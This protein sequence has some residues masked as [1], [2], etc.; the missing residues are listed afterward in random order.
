M[1]AISR[2]FPNLSI[3]VQIDLGQSL[4]KNIVITFYKAVLRYFLCTKFEI[5]HV[6][7]MS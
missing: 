5:F 3:K 1:Q 2:V 6:H 4:F 7:F